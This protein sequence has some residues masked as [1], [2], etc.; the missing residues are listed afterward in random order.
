M[1]VVDGDTIDTAAIEGKA[2]RVRVIGIDAP[3]TDTC[4][5]GPATEDMFWLV[6]NKQVAL[7]TGGDGKDTDRYGRYCATST[8]MVSM[9]GCR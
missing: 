8:S 3:E 2:F 5:D 4:Q 9:P 1:H 7:T 6:Q